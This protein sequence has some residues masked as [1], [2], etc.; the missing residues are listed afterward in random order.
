MKY[1]TIFDI[2]YKNREKK[3]DFIDASDA[4]LKSTYTEQYTKEEL[5]EKLIADIK[6]QIKSDVRLNRTY[7]NVTTYSG[8][9]EKQVLPEVAEYFKTRNYKVDLHNNEDYSDTNVLIIN[10]QNNENFKKSTI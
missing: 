4:Y 1:T 10:W 3:D 9:R 8:Y 7:I 5:K 2:F 6:R